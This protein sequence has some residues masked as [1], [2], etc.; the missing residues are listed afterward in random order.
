MSKIDEKIVQKLLQ[1]SDPKTDPITLNE[2]VKENNPEININ[3]PKAVIN[4][5]SEKISVFNSEKS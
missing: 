4:S 2:L 1:S 3:T 5:L